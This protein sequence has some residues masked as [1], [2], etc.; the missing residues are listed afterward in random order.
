MGLG[1]YAS[2]I[3][4]RSL[5]ALQRP[6]FGDRQDRHQLEQGSNLLHAASCFVCIGANQ[7]RELFR[8]FSC[9]SVMQVLANDDRLWVASWLADWA[10]WPNPHG[11]ICYLITYFV[12]ARVSFSEPLCSSCLNS[13]EN[14]RQIL[15]AEQRATS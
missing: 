6:Q 8:D 10:G 9:A 7:T 13:S 14:E 4:P 15:K 3:M 12:F 2:A 11:Q 5:M 1:D